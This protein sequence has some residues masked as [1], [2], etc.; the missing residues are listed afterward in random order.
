MN[1][2]VLLK[3]SFTFLFV[4]F[5]LYAQQDPFQDAHALYSRSEWQEAKGA[6]ERAFEA[7]KQG[8]AQ[9]DQKMLAQGHVGYADVLWATAA[10][11]W[12]DGKTEQ[13]MA[14]WIDAGTHRDYRL[15]LGQFGRKPLGNEEWD[16][17]DPRGK[18]IVV[19]SERD[20]GAFGDTFA[21]SFLPRYLKEKGATVVF[22]PQK[23]LKN[24]YEAQGTIQSAYIDKVVL[25][26]EELP[27]HDAKIY[28]WSIFPYD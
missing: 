17:S 28:L 19:Y 1:A 9:A 11:D 8:A 10:G 2:R 4:G 3:K 24:M 18:T 20:G 26:D 14:A 12:Y 16:G 27:P 25:R 22:V 21:M 23:P 6:Y 15:E 13:A 5:S 7:I